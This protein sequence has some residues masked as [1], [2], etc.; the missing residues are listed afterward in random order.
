MT[1]QLPCRQAARR[2]IPAGGRELAGKLR[3][4]TREELLRRGEALRL[5]V[6]QILPDGLV[7]GLVASVSARHQIC[8]YEVVVATFV[9]T[10]DRVEHAA[11]EFNTAD[12]EAVD[13]PVLKLTNEVGALPAIEA[14][15]H[16]CDRPRN[17]LKIQLGPPNCRQRR[18]R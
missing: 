16:H 15:L 17:R 18:D 2:R 13:I 7:V 14:M 1:V 4:P 8:G 3:A 6:A 11:D 10:Q 5:V 9:G 12:D